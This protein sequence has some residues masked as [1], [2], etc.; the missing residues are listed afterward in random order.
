M[1][2]LT[3]RNLE[4]VAQFVRFCVCWFCAATPTFLA[5]V[6][7][8]R[9][10]TVS[11][12]VKTHPPINNFRPCLQRSQATASR[13][14]ALPWVSH[15][16][17]PPILQRAV[18]HARPRRP[19]T[20]T[21]SQRASAKHSRLWAPN[22]TSKLSKLLCWS[23]SARATHRLAAH[24]RLPSLRSTLRPDLAAVV[25]PHLS[26]LSRCPFRRRSSPAT[27]PR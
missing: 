8:L 16:E 4:L 13:A 1:N 26:H 7:A 6:C 27:C 24:L 10:R 20:G 15:V 22:P 3:L 12:Y 18:R 21:W 19:Q 23:G 2:F 11:V 17:C 9:K 5:P 14:S 25:R